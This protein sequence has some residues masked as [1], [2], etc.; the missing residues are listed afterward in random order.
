MRMSD[1]LGQLRQRFARFALP[2]ALRLW[3]IGMVY[4]V[5]LLLSLFSA[6]LLRLDFDLSAQDR[7]RL[8]DVIKTIAYLRES[9]AERSN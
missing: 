8:I 3:A 2:P 1:L 7:E 4:G 5:L 6:Y 9:N